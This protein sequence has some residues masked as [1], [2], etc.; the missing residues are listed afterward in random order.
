MVQ[1]MNTKALLTLASV[2]RRPGLMTPHVSVDTVSEINYA[3]L[4]ERCGIH[5]VV[6]DKDNTLTAPYENV[7]HPNARAGL[8]TA[9]ETFGVSN[10][11]ILSN[12]A[13]TKDDPDYE[14]AIA[15]EAALGI[16]VIKHDEKK[17]G[18]LEETLQHFGM[19]DPSAVCMVG[20]RLLTDVVFGNLYGMLTVHTMP[21]C[22]GD[23]NA[24]DNKVAKVIRGAENKTLYGNWFGGRWLLGKQLPH[25]Y[26]PGPEECPLVLISTTTA[27]GN[28]EDNND[29]NND[30]NNAPA[31]E[32]KSSD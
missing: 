3:L 22:S 9:I 17:P 24:R 15:I 19:E 28:T 10:V 8:A 21:L 18:G 25:K 7:I 30:S 2:A 27:T 12:S 4:K 32:T 23:D 1:S 20:D 13:G 26:W 29:S 31:N 11:A 6:F 16:A 5:A 14:D